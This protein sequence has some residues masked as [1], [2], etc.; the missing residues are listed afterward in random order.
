MK[1]KCRK[2]VAIMIISAMA[3]SFSITAFA[4]YLDNG[5]I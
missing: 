1:L 4:D 3:I 2:I 5:A